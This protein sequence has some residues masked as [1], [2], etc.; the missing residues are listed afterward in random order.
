MKVASSE[1]KFSTDSKD[2]VVNLTS[3]LKSKVKNF[4]IEEGI[5]LA[6]APH[7]TGVL[8]LNENESG[9]K[10]DYL[11]GIYEMVPEKNNYKH[12]RIDSNA[13]SHIKSAFF[14]QERIIPITK[15]SLDLGTWQ[16]LFFIETDGPRNKRKVI[17]KAIGE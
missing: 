16:N 13:H 3:Q 7:A 12:D 4:D 8:V 9:V 1:I 11:K 5:C 17:A 14:G 10:E 6:F 2:Q 15:G